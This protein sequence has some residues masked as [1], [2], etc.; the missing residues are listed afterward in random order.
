[1][2]VPKNYIKPM[3][4]TIS[5][6]GKPD[7]Y[8]RIEHER[9]KIKN[10]KKLTKKNELKLIYKYFNLLK[11]FFLYRKLAKRSKLKLEFIAFQILKYNYLT[12]NHLIDLLS[13]NSGK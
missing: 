11:R 9:E 5:Y 3:K 2:N 10:I 6:T 13:E 8:M 1:M 4:Q 12:I 7:I